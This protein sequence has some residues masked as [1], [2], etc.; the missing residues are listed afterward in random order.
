[1]G[2]E[3]PPFD[4]RVLK[5]LGADEYVS[6]LY[7]GPDA[8]VV[9]LY[10]GYYRTQRQGD[11]MHSPLNCLPGA[12]WQPVS[13]GRVVIPIEGREPIE[14]NRYIVQKGEERQ[15]VLYWYQSQSRV[16]ASEYWG[17]VYLVLDAIRTR[18]SDAA[19][20]RVTS[21]IGA[22]QSEAEAAGY[23]VDF[24]KTMFPRLVEHLPS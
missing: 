2:R 24:V 11:T 9:G 23:A 18:R 12:G 5:T 20:I 14:V 7:S 10:V 15:L 13:G 17:K 4:D 8:N 6:R 1:M 21:P 19:L 3:L 22:R 16:V